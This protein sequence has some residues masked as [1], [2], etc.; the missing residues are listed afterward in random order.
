VST[1]GLA[2]VSGP[3]RTRCTGLTASMWDKTTYDARG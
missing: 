1:S 2:Q 3:F